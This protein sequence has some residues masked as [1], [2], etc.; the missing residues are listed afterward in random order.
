MSSLTRRRAIAGIGGVALGGVGLATMGRFSDRH[1]RVGATADM[2]IADVT[3]T[4]DGPPSAVWL[5]VDGAYEYELASDA[6][7]DAFRI[8]LFVDYDGDERRLAHETEMDPP[9]SDSGTYAFESDILEHGGVEAGDLVDGIGETRETT[10]GVAIEAQL[11]D[12]GGVLESTRLEDSVTLAL[13][14][15]GTV[16]SVTAGGEVTVEG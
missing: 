13:T 1:G 16:L 11:I 5:A 4:V 3:E 2:E 15:D 6:T 7:V 14:Q 8:E 9:E 12:N 10:F